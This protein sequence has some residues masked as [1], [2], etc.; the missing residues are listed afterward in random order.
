MLQYSLRSGNFKLFDNVRFGLAHL[1]KDGIHFNDN[2]KA[3]LSACWVY[4]VLVRLGK[5]R[6][7]T[8]PLRPNFVRMVEN[9]NSWG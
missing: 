2:G 3:V 1:A 9:Y 8:L 5:I 4:C 7:R 6:D